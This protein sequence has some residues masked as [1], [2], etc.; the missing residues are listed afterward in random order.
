[1]SAE[2]IKQFETLGLSASYHFADDTG[3]EF[4]QGTLKKRAALKLFDDNPELQ[5]EMRVVAGGFL[6][7]LASERKQEQENG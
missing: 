7:S 2:I 4:R 1:M 3:K 5:N 6:W